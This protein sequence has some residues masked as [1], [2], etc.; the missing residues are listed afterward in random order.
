[1]WAS[2]EHT[3]KEAARKALGLKLYGSDINILNFSKIL[4]IE[5]GEVEILEFKAY[6]K[7]RSL[8]WN[9]Q[10]WREGWTSSPPKKEEN[11][12]KS[13]KERKRERKEAA[14]RARE[15]NAKTEEEKLI[16]S[17]PEHIEFWENEFHPMAYR[18]KSG[19]F[20]FLFKKCDGC[21]N[22]Y[23]TH[24][25]EKTEE[26]FIFCPTCLSELDS[27][28]GYAEE[29]PAVVHEIAI[30]AVAE[31]YNTNP[32]FVNWLLFDIDDDELNYGDN[33]LVNMYILFNDEYEE[34]YKELTGES[35]GAAQH[36]IEVSEEKDDDEVLEPCNDP[37]CFYQNENTI[38]YHHVSEEVE[39][40]D[41]PE[42]LQQE[43]FEDCGVEAFASAE[44]YFEHIEEEHKEYPQLTTTTELVRQYT[45]P[46]V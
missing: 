40:K 15:W 32:D 42:G 33:T 11:K 17:D 18:V 3:I 31:K 43:E 38:H 9:E 10:A 44:E 20:I 37:E 7:P 23:N 36:L 24:Y 5:N 29:N 39:V 6:Q 25:L 1:M 12:K 34:V 14:K 21:E 4:Y 27:E 13:K 2:T 26:G 46:T 8:T 45:T 28:S 30:E 22:N 16:A 41:I 35:C 19:N